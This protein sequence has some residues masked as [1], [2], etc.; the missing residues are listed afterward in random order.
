MRRDLGEGAVE[1][2]RGKALE[3]KD[4]GCNYLTR[5]RSLMLWNG[6]D[7]GGGGAFRRNYVEDGIVLIGNDVKEKKNNNF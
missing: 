5:K 6:G 7:G 3:D 4:R 2:D 1:V